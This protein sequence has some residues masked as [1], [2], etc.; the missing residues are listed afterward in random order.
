MKNKKRE[1][2]FNGKHAVVVSGAGTGKT[3]TIVHRALHLLNTGVDPKKTLILSFTKKYV[4]TCMK[5][6]LNY[7]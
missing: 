3:R 6:K 4:K 5:R 2:C 7:F 1:V